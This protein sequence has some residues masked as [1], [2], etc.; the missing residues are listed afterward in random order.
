[1][2]GKWKH[3]DSIIAIL[4]L[5]AFCAFA[6]LIFLLSSYFVGNKQA[7]EEP[8]AGNI[9][10]KGMHFGPFYQVVTENNGTSYVTKQ[11]Y[12]NLETGDTLTGYQ[13]NNLSFF[14]PLDI[15]HDGAALIVIAVFL[16]SLIISFCFYFYDKFFRKEKLPPSPPRRKRLK[17]LIN[18][19]LILYVII[20]CCIILLVISNLL[21]RVIPIGQTDT[22]AKIV[23]QEITKGYGR[24]ATNT[25]DFFIAFT[26]KDGKEYLVKKRINHHIYNKYKNRYQLPIHYQSKNPANTFVQFQT[27]RDVSSSILSASTFVFLAILYSYTR[28]YS[29]WKKNILIKN[30][31]E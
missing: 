16:G 14:T 15:L 11:Q 8:V 5:I 2:K 23:D 4:L 22:K 26:D 30:K 20:S 9:A 27:V 10:I 28:I 3:I 13:T 17:K 12:Y 7:V 18:Y 24:Y 25:Y 21:L 1:M 19:S 29:R 31:E 6:F